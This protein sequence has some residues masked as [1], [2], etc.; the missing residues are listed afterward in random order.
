[1]EL[2]D[3]TA[4]IP[5]TLAYSVKIEPGGHRTV[6]LECSRQLEAK[7]DIRV[8][9]GFHHRNPNVC[10][11]PIVYITLEMNFIPNSSHLPYLTLVE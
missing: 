3:T 9:A 10:I 5:L 7:M 8:D 4:G 11:P 2:Q 6:P 1:M